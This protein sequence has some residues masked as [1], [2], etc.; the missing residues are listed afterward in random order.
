M[1]IMQPQR[2]APTKT[3]RVQTSPAVTIVTDDGKTQVIQI[4]RNHNEMAALI[5]QRDAL[6]DQVEDLKDQRNDVIEQLRTAPSEAR[7]GLQLQLTQMSTQIVDL[8]R[9]L[10]QIGRDI[11]GASPDLIAMTR[12]EEP[13]EHLGTFGEGVGVGALGGIVLAT[14]AML[15]TRAIRRR[16]G[17]G[18]TARARTLAA[19]DSER[20]KR[21]ENGI[22]AMA[23]EIE[24][25]SEGQRF[26]TKLMAESR[27]FESTPR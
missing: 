5:A 16:F 9:Q 1:T 3:V 21:L 7:P 24:R 11:S 8:Q 2:E 6:T 13:S 25:I 14:V 27:G 19:G 10:S 26:V 22:D 12:D 18:D 20:L 23:V 4:P 17:R 15:L